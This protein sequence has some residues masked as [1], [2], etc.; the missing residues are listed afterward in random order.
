MST[1]VV[2]L[3]LVAAA[4]LLVLALAVRIAKQYD[5]ERCLAKIEEL[6]HDLLTS[7]SARFWR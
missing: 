7:G 5:L 4:A 3:L 6:E 2:V 1:F